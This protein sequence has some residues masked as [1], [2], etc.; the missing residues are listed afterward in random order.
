MRGMAYVLDALVVIRFGLVDLPR[1]YGTAAA[2]DAAWS[3]Y[4]PEMLKRLALF[5]VPVG[6]F[7]GSYGLVRANEPDAPKDEREWNA[8]LLL[9]AVGGLFLMLNLEIAQTFGAFLP[10]A[11]VPMLTMLWIGLCVFLLEEAI[12]RKAE[13]WLML[14]CV[15][16]GGLA[17]KLVA[18]DLP[19]WAHERLLVG[20]FIFGNG[21]DYAGVDALMRLWDCVAVLAL[22]WFVF[23]RLRGGTKMQKDV[24]RGFAVAAV[25]V[26]FIFSSLELST[27]LAVFAPGMR[28]GGVSVLWSIFAL[29]LVAI[30][31]AKDVRPARY[32]GL[33]MFAVVVAKVFAVDLA[34]AT[35]VARVIAFVALSVIL[36][37]RIVRVFEEPGVV[38]AE[39]RRKS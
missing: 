21:A 27:V 24:G 35:Q 10:A 7:A 5:G 3:A 37:R 19:S 4:W 26:L 25:V 30:G 36:M 8:V 1:E 2:A 6:C 33:A 22:C 13:A 15:A 38:F 29:A 34:R 20:S 32:A 12:R 18:F 9:G 31:I 11:K 28:D 23:A 16:A 39:E 14:F 17:A